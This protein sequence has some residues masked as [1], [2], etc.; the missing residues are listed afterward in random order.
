MLAGGD[1]MKWAAKVG[2]VILLACCHPMITGC[3]TY[4]VWHLGRVYEYASCTGKAIKAP[5]GSVA[6]EVRAH[7]KEL[8]GPGRSTA[9]DEHGRTRYLVG[10]RE[11]VT[12]SIATALSE[13]KPHDRD[14]E[15]LNISPFP[16][17]HRSGWVV[18]P[19]RFS[20]RDAP[21]S[22]LP[23]VFHDES[24]VAYS[25]HAP[26][27]YEYEGK[28]YRLTMSTGG[29]LYEGK[30]ARTKLRP[31]AIPTQAVLLAP[32]LAVDIVTFPVQLAFLYG[33][34]TALDNTSFPF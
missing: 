28:T 6:F 22:I 29:G 24:A 17:R 30:A 27:P 26:V 9:A 20:A 5:D 15:W 13:R 10:D 25:R 21:M 2:C 23:A 32:A 18:L 4:T 3:A 34:K 33:L 8:G 16:L 31:W 1:A 19:G 7:Y 14:S 12:K 11:T